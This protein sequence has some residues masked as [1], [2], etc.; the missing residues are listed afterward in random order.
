MNAIS[1]APKTVLGVR[2]DGR[3][4]YPIAGGS[5]PVPEGIIVNEPPAPPV[6][7]Q[8]F[9]AEDIAKARSQERDKLHSDLEKIKAAAKQAESQN[10]AF[11]DELAI[12]RKEREDRAAEEAARATEKEAARKAKFEEDASAKD[13]LK[14]KEAE[15]NAKFAEAEAKREAERQETLFEKAALQKEREYLAL[16]DYTQRRVAE[17]ADDIVPEFLDYISG[18]TED[19]IETSITTAKAK[20]QAILD[21][22]KQQ[23]NSSRAQVRG[24]SPSGYAVTGPSEIPSGTRSFSVE[25]LKAMNVGEYAKYRDSLLGASATQNNRGLYG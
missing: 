7:P 3:F 24:A 18:N 15:W 10:A 23:T 1:N 6:P 22:V 5:E 21:I 11:A 19:E 9:T 4:I 25:E 8:T 14:V 13:L 20:S 2:K 12:L 17:E 16:R